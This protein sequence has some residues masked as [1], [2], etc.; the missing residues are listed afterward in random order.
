MGTFIIPCKY[1][2]EKSLLR[3]C[4]SSIR[5][6]HPENEI[7]IIDSDSEDK[8]YFDWARNEFAVEIDVAFNKNY[9]TGAIWRAYNNHEREFYY[10]LHDSVELIDNISEVEKNNLSVVMHG[11]RWEWP[12]IDTS[13]L[14]KN[15]ARSGEW[16]KDNINQYVKTD[17]REHGFNSILGPMFCC[18]RTILEKIYETGFHK[19]L[20]TNKS[21][22][23]N[24]E[25]LWGYIF[26]EV[27]LEK[28]LE[29][30]SILGPFRHGNG[31]GEGSA[32]I[33]HSIKLTLDGVNVKKNV[34]KDGDK[35]I[36]YWVRRQ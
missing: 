4:L 24:M 12:R 23:E 10:F 22:S 3:R 33:G 13:K 30:N 18:K 16:A 2:K 8:S 11:K 26:A 32:K 17:F 34:H 20:P 28:E 19:V 1:V 14:E 21:Q 27:G 7:I 6:C 36:K 29:N 35:L 31:S 25:R 5:K 9:T 15:S